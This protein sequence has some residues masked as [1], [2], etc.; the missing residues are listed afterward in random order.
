MVVADYNV[1]PQAP[2][3]P[4]LVDVGDPAIGRDQQRHAR[5]SNLS[6]SFLAQPVTIISTGDDH[7]G[8]EPKLAQRIEH[9]G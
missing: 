2:S 7:L 1:Y 5:R 3:R 9:D 6:H 4:N 8:T